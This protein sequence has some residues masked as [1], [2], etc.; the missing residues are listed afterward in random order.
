MSTLIYFA[1]ADHEFAS[2]LANDLRVAGFQTTLWQGAGDF[3]GYDQLIL[4][5][6]AAALQAAAW[7]MPYR[8]FIN[9]G[10]LVCSARVDNTELPP[11][12]AALEWVDFSLGYQLGVNGLRVSLRTTPQ[13]VISEPTPLAV[14]VTASR[15]M[16]LISIAIA[17]LVLIIGLLLIFVIHSTF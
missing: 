17:I 1:G 10:K 15:R 16:I 13:P 7:Q 5:I 9:A 8:A 3:T 4:V 2:K 6:S 14:P 11:Q 12:L